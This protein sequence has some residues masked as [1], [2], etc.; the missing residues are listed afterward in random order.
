MSSVALIASMALW[1]GPAQVAPSTRAANWVVDYREGLRLELIE[2]DMNGALAA[3]RRTMMRQPPTVYA[4]RARYR[5]ANVLTRVGREEEAREQL[6]LLTRQLQEAD[7]LRADLARRLAQVDMD[8]DEQT[9]Y[10]EGKLQRATAARDL[11]KLREAAAFLARYEDPK[12]ADALLRAYETLSV[13]EPA[14]EV[15]LGY[16]AESESPGAVEVIREALGDADVSVVTAA[17]YAIGAIGDG[18]SDERLIDLLGSDQ[19]EIR[20]AAVRSLGRLRSLRA[21]EPLVRIVDRDEVESVRESAVGALRCIGSRRGMDVVAGYPKGKGTVDCGCILSDAYQA[22]RQDRWVPQPS[23]SAADNEGRDE[24]RGWWETNHHWAPRIGVV[25]SAM[26]HHGPD[27]HSLV[28]PYAGQV[29]KA[30]TLQRA[31][32]EVCLLAEPEVLE[33]PE[34]GFLRTVFQPGLPIHPLGEWPTCDVIL[35]DQLHHLPKAVVR[36]LRYFCEGGGKLIVCGAACGGICGDGVAW[37]KIAQVRSAEAHSFRGETVKLVWKGLE[38]SDKWGTLSPIERVGRRSGT[39]YEHQSIDGQVLAEFDWPP[40]YAVKTQPVSRGQALLFNWDVGLSV[41]GASDE[42]ELLCRAIDLLIDETKPGW[43]SP[44]Y[45]LMR[46]V[47]WDELSAAKKSAGPAALSRLQAP[48]QVETLAQLFRVYLMENNRPA[49]ELACLQAAE[50][51]EDAS[52]VYAALERTTRSPRRVQIGTVVE[53]TPVWWRDVPDWMTL[54]ASESDSA[55]RTSGVPLWL[56]APQQ[57][58]ARVRLRTTVARELAAGVSFVSTG[59]TIEFIESG[60]GES[61]QPVNQQ[62]CEVPVDS[63]ASSDR[64]IELELTMSDW[65]ARVGIEVTP[66]PAGEGLIER[67]EVE[68][69]RIRR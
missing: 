15:L 57:L 31:G 13:G 62:R 12:G 33:D 36:T 48:E 2:G 53:G 37:R 27:C 32:F 39:F 20:E 6:R 66:K 58:P 60:L 67:T 35:L 9:R 21:V 19:P 46:R 63:T 40:T 7:P 38:T 69:G 28:Q 18:E 22:M 16:L 34:A 17:I 14:R 3:Y 65:N 68:K 43:V 47:R 11:G 61:R 23:F 26:T 29:R 25:V 24:T 44:L 8:A 55:D 56:T 54:T 41:N 42:D 10:W 4:Q 50:V 5:L 52:A 30:W 59:A 1:T 45:Q 64:W 49:G 51:L